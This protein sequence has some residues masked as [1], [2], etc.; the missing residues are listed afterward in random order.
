LIALW[1][2]FELTVYGM[3]LVFSLLAVLWGLIALLVRLDNPPVAE[4]APASAA[5]A[6][7]ADALPSE[8]AET[9]AAPVR[10][11]IDP[12][13]LAAIF[14]ACRAHRM[15]RRKQA[16][17]ELRM[18]EPGSLPSRWVGSGRTRQNRSWAPG[19]RFA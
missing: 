13:L 14:I 11:A 8:H 17:P 19:G 2:G 6:R 16:A 5:A 18:H 9:D 3:G 4:E 1:I 15:A 10:A 7:R 12:A